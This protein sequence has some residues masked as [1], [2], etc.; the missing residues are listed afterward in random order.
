MDAYVLIDHDN[1]PSQFANAGLAGLAAR[2]FAVLSGS[3]NNLNDVHVRLYGGWYDAT[4][5]L[6]RDGT[7]VAQEIGRDF[8]MTKMSQSRQIQRV[9]CEIASALI[10]SPQDLFPFTFRRRSGIRSRLSRNKPPTCAAP[11]KCSI[12][13]VAAWS[14]GHCPESG[15][16]VT[17]ETVFA[18]NEQKLVDTM[19]CCDILALALR[20]PLTPIA[21]LS[22]DDDLAPAVLM[23]AKLGAPIHLIEMRANKQGTYRPL[24][25][26]YNVR[27]ANL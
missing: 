20:K 21:V 2:V 18:Y 10:D 8:P 7:R 23:A 27:T 1:V 15:C 14:R 11:G 26:A 3:I 13:A 4:G 16:S 19:L 17:T 5:G 9:A 22:D 24:F 12:D 6:T 25:A